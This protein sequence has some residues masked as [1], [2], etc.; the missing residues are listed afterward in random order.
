VT[1]T[2]KSRLQNYLGDYQKSEGEL[3]RDA[4]LSILGRNSRK[5]KV[6]VTRRSFVEAVTREYE[7]SLAQLRP[8]KRQLA[9]TDR[10]IDQVVYRLYGLSEEE[11]AV[12]EGRA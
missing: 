3:A 4:L 12:V 11:I 7:T 2:N 10:L 6:G 8:I 9:L 1:V 5:L